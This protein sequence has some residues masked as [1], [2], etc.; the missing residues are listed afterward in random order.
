MENR[1]IIEGKAIPLEIS[2]IDTDQ[3]IPAEFL[4]IVEKKGLSKYLFYRMRYDECGR[5]TGK[6]P[7]DMPEYSNASILI[8]SSNFGIG[9]SRENAVW[10][11]L[12][13]G[14]KCVIASSFGDIFYNNALKNKL[15]CIKIDEERLSEM[16][17]MARNHEKFIVDLEKNRIIV[18]NK[19]YDFDLDFEIK[20][21]ILSNKD[22]IS[23]TLEKYCK[24]IERYEMSVPKFFL[25]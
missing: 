17:R 5:L 11:L 7:L 12:D 13:A 19:V 3:I 22:E 18:S 10:A 21:R 6:F 14:I 8:T 15:L 4:K 1:G 25:P 23:E 9:S 16:R 2:D 20:N 24:L